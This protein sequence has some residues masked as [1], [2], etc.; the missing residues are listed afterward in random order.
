MGLHEVT[1]SNIV[2]SRYS[3]LRMMVNVC[4]IISL[5]RLSIEILW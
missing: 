2:K 3:S 5:L 4:A 1:F